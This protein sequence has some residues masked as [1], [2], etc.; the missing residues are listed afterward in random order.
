MFVPLHADERRFNCAEV[1]SYFQNGQAAFVIWNVLGFGGKANPLV[2][3]RIASLAARAGQALLDVQ[4]ARLQLY[5]DDPA[6]V[7]VGDEQA[8]CKE[9]DV[10]LSFWLLLGLKL[11]W[12]KGFHAVTDD[13]HQYHPAVEHTWIGITYSIVHGHA[14]MYLT[15]E[16]IDGALV[17]FR[18]LAHPRGTAALAV[19]R[20]AAGKASRIACVVPDASPFAAAVWGALTGS[21]R[22]ADSSRPEAPKGYVSTVRFHIAAGW[23]IALLARAP[24]TVRHTLRTRAESVCEPSS[25]AFSAASGVVFFDTSPWDGV[26]VLL[27][28]GSLTEWF[29]SYVGPVYLR[30]TQRRGRKLQTPVHMGVRHIVYRHVCV[31]VAAGAAPLVLRRQH[32]RTHGCAQPRRA[33]SYAQGC[34]GDRMAQSPA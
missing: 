18:S 8:C 13:H 24:D 5:V 26:A 25:E 9:L 22:A 32:W 15:L 10:L 27:D 34:A 21:F 23:L 33:R 7:V 12:H 28:Q 2:Y 11:S 20:S 16:F 19:A 4:R 31:A 1:P 30:Y 29:F 3:A 14:L 6:V 17:I